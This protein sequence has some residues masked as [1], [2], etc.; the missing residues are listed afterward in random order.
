V[1]DDGSTDGTDIVVRQMSDFAW[2]TLIRLNRNFGKEIALSAGLRFSESDAAILIDAD[3]QHPF[4]CIDKFI[5]EWQKGFDMVYAVHSK[6]DVSFVGKYIKPLFSDLLMKISKVDIPANAGDFRLLDKSL[7][8]L[9]NKF[10]E[11]SRYMKGLYPLLTNNSSSFEYTPSERRLGISKFSFRDLVGLAFD[12]IA[13]FS[14]A[15]LKLVIALGLF[16]SLTS[17]LFSAYVVL[18]TVFFGNSASGWPSLIVAV[19]FLFGLQF[20]VLGIIGLYV[21]KIFEEVKNRPLFSI[22]KNASFNL[23]RN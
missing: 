23:D 5:S 1:V 2:L 22:D 19:T 13:S 17:V 14:I 10:D 11:S 9:L 12:G 3:F 7:V 18:D 8:E 16:V 20:I 21:G 6:R 4:N 15:P